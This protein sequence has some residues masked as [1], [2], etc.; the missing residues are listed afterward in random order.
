MHDHRTSNVS[1]QGASAVADVLPL[2]ER[3]LGDSPALGAGLRGPTWID[4]DDFAPGALS[5]V[6]DHLDECAPRCVVNVFGQHSASET[7]DVDVF[8]RDATESVD[9]LPA[10]VVQ[11][12]SAGICDAVMKFCNKQFT[13]AP[14]LGAALTTSKG[15]LSATQL[16]RVPLC[17]IWSGDSLAITEC[18]E[19][20]EAEVNA[21][22]VGIGSFCGRD[23]DVEND[24][25]LA[26]P[27]RQDRGLRFTWKITVPTHL[28]IAGHADERELPVLANTEPVA[29]AEVG[30]AVVVPSLKAREASGYAAPY[31]TEERLESFVDLPHHLLLSGRRPAPDVRQVATDCRETGDLLVSLDADALP[32]SHNAMLKG[33]IV[34]LAEVRKH[35]AQEHTLRPVRLDAVFVAQQHSAA[36]QTANKLADDVRDCASALLGVGGNNFVLRFWKSDVDR[37]LLLCHKVDHNAIC[38]THQPLDER[39]GGVSSVR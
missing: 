33:S 30:R 21:N 37:A 20:R 2:V 25:P 32:V 13:L 24:V 19:A 38:I 18:N 1:I 12:V 16:A 5:L 31:A 39:K 9:K 26:R 17:D 35:L 27:S 34:K 14:N 7:L 28:D 8:E 11:E 6:C 23:L 22:R 10:F 4:L 15:A 36:F 3:L 29:N